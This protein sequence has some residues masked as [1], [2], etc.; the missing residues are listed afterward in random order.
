[1]FNQNTPSDTKIAV[2][3]ERLSSYELMMK[4]IDEA[5]QIMGKT[6]QNISKMLAVHDERIEQC[7]KTDTMISNLINDLKKE[8]KE[9]HES[10]S[11]RIE[12]VELRLE[13]VIKF[14]WIILG[15]VSVVTFIFSQSTMVVDL[16]TPDNTP[17]KV[18]LRK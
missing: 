13:E 8:N 5:I 4:K 10:V 11:S 18:E 12:K 7:A 2:L 6:S 16:L 15:V 17:A 1:M 14:R 3:E 9:Q